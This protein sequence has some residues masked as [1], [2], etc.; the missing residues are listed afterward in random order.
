M[1]EDSEAHTDVLILERDARCFAAL[2]APVRGFER[3]DGGVEAA[4]D[5]AVSAA[6]LD[7]LLGLT[8]DEGAG[9][10]IVWI[11]CGRARVALRT[12]ASMR[13]AQLPPAAFWRLPRLLRRA[14]CASWVRGVVD[15]GHGADMGVV[16]AVWIDLEDAA[17]APPAPPVD[18]A[19]HRLADAFDG[20][21][22]RIGET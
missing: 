6:D 4:L 21:N 8:P 2:L 12:A 14:G 3:A 16:L 18:N 20:T 13:L 9:A 10:R 19:G 17:A 1:T 22:A 5:A 7:A 11:A 15:V